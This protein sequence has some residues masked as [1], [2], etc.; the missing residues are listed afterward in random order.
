[1]YNYLI[2]IWLGLTKFL[3]VHKK[4]DKKAKTEVEN[5]VQKLQFFRCFLR[6]REVFT[7]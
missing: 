5:R 6:L 7:S 4:K 3:E 2:L 1:M